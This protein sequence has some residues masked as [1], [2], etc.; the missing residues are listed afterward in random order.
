VMVGSDLEWERWHEEISRARR[1][2][3]WRAAI[4]VGVAFYFFLMVA[5]AFAADLFIPDHSITPGVVSGNG[6]CSLVRTSDISAE[7][8]A[9]I[10]GPHRMDDRG[11]NESALTSTPSLE[12]RAKVSMRPQSDRAVWGTSGATVSS[13]DRPPLRRLRSIDGKPAGFPSASIGPLSSHQVIASAFPGALSGLGL[14]E[15][16]YSHLPSEKVCSKPSKSSLRPPESRQ[17][18]IGRSVAPEVPDPG[19]TPGM[20]RE[21]SLDQVC[22]TSWS[23]DKRHVTVKMKSEV[24]V[25][26]NLS[27][28]TDK[29]CKLDRHG[30][31]FEIDHLVSRELGGADVVENL[32]PQCYSGRWNAVMKDRLENRLHKEVCSG[33][34]S[35]EHAQNEIR[36][37][38]RIPYRRYFGEPKEPK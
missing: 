34:L 31:R 3:L 14:L 22:N 17:S 36:L 7:Y 30:R 38:W 32:W 24:F 20:A 4:I 35:L 37:D 26:Y 8:L 27:G 11:G 28:N 23:K 29:S 19:L 12:R 5:A 9:G 1:W 16:K 25:L 15:R 33:N 10:S 13:S 2:Q 18:K 6:E 21:L